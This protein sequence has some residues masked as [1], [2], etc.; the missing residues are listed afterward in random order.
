MSK[1]DVLIPVYNAESFLVNTIESVLRQTYTDWQLLILDDCSTDNSYQ[2]ALQY[3]QKF[4][5]I[6]VY[7]NDANIG[8]LNNWNKG[9]DLCHSDYFVKLDADDIWEPTMLEKATKILNEK[10]E[11]GLVFSR[12][13]NINENGDEIPGTDLSFPDFATNCSFSCIPIVLEGPDKMLSYP[14]LLQGLSV[15]RRE[16]FNKI[17]KYSFLLSKATQASTDTE[18]YFRLGCHYQIFCIDE[19]LYKYRIHISSISN[20]DRS[21]DISS[22]KV[23]ELKT[24][25]VKYY[26]QQNKIT[27]EKSKYF[28]KKIVFDYKTY[29][30]YRYRV[31]RDYCKMI[32]C[33]F[34]NFCSFPKLFL[35]FY[36]VRI[37]KVHK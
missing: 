22:L 10:S 8:M 30:V 11:V 32:K 23:Y 28:Y 12:Y 16:I 36:F 25:I 19:V 4:E 9:I 17:G 1:V 20:L 37:G 29:L 21:N 35:I 13:I 18:F 3:A 34:E 5:K 15:M 6:S 14:I 7:K 27:L 31:N 24:S 2:I 33:L 26:V